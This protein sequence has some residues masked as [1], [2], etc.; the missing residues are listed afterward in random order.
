MVSDS[1]T[2]WATVLGAAQSRT[3]LNDFT[4]TFHFHAMEKAMATHSSTLAWRIPWTEEPG[5]CSLWN[6]SRTQLSLHFT[7]ICK[8]SSDSHFAFLHFFFL[9]IVLISVSCT[10]SQTSIYRSS[11]SLSIRCSSLNLFLTSHCIIV[12]DLI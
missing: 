10:M 11:G 5:G 6:Q 3:Q 12:K 9:G 8:A 2:L 7:A 1:V 4:F